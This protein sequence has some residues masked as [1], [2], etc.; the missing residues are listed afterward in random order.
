MICIFRQCCYV[1]FAETQVAAMSIPINDHRFQ[2]FEQQIASRYL[3]RILE[4]VKHEPLKQVRLAFAEA[5]LDYDRVRQNPGGLARYDLYHLLHELNRDACCPGICLRFGLA[6]DLLDLGVLG[7]A[8]LS[9]RDLGMAMEVIVKFHR[10]TSNAFEMAIIEEGE[11]TFARQWIKPQYARWRVVIDE[12]HVTGIWRVISSLLHSEPSMTETRIEFAHSEPKY[13]NLCRDLLGGMPIFGVPE[14]SIGFPTAWLSRPVHTAD[15][16]VEQVCESQCDQ[17]VEQLRPAGDLVDD[18]RRLILTVPLNCAPKLGNIASKMLISTRTLERRLHA[19]GTSFRKIE[20]EVRMQ[21]AAQYLALGYMSA[22]E[23][24]Y[25]LGY[26]Q[27]GTFYR[28]FKK[29]YGVTPKVY[30]ADH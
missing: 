25:M 6:R 4:L 1:P 2:E 21:L 11:W 22:T 13:G 26:S 19:A 20:N 24:A 7:Y 3:E 15:H 8:V 14:T 23:I 30:A 27:P 17:L 28:A 12:E 10:L 5:G 18:V 9:C 16:T 29:W